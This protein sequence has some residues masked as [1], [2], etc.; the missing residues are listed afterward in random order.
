MEACST[1]NIQFQQYRPLNTLHMNISILI[2]IANNRQP[3]REIQEV[4]SIVDAVW[5]ATAGRAE[6]VWACRQSR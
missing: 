3:S 6:E 1:W 5:R 4:R 2:M